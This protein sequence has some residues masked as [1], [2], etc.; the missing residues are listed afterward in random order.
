MKVRMQRLTSRSKIALLATL[1]SAT[2]AAATVLA[3]GPKPGL[4]LASCHL[5]PCPF[6][7]SYDPKTAWSGLELTYRLTGAAPEPQ[8]WRF[9]R[10]DRGRWRHELV[11]GRAP[12]T[13]TISDGRTEY[14]Y[15]PGVG[16]LEETIYARAY[17]PPDPH[18]VLSPLLV[19]RLNDP[20][21]WTAIGTSKLQGF[22]VVEVISK[23]G[24]ERIAVNPAHGLPVR[25]TTGKLTWELVSARFGQSFT[26]GQFQ[27]PTAKT[28]VRRDV[29]D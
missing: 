24:S 21:Q 27:P 16:Q 9:I 1:T 19:F 13:L 17:G 22:D 15:F 3:V 5:S 2:L 18:Q 11:Q 10:D 20:T 14:T 8:V 12:A 7:A 28:V 6:A 4:G 26:E 29:K 25:H 23:D